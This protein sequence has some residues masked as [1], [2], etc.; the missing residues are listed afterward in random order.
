MIMLMTSIDSS[1]S[2]QVHGVKQRNGG[3]LFGSNCK[4]FSQENE[5]K[6]GDVC[7]F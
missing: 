4:M 5:L 2:W 7:T 1:R 6:V 3:Y